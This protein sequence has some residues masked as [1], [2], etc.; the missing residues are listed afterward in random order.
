MRRMVVLGLLVVAGAVTI[1]AT[2][3]PQQ[4]PNVAEIEKV[5]DN[6][7]MIKGGG[8]NTAAFVTAT[9][10]VLVDTKLANWGPAIMDKVRSVTDKPVT[11]IVNTHTHGDHTGSNDYFPASV[12]VI[13]QENTKTNMQKMKQF[14]GENAKFLP[15]RTYKDRETLLTGA[16]RIDLYYFGPGHTNGDTIVVFPELRVAHTGDLSTL[17]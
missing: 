15:D 3:A 10:V 16:D 1:S 12:E 2:Q 13:A 6:L 4:G 9:G 17:R 5:R 14:E 7:F 8:G 11:M